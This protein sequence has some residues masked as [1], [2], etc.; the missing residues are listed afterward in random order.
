MIQEMLGSYIR[1]AEGLG[2]Y[3]SMTKTELANGYCDADDAHDE[4]KKNQ[5]FSALMVRYWFKVYD[6][7]RNS[8][9]T[10][11]ELEDY[12]SWVSEAL[13]IGLKYRRWR[14]PSHPL[15]KDPDAPD[16]VFNRALFSTRKRWFMYLN[17]NKRKINFV[18]DSIERQI[19]IFEDAADVLTEHVTDIGVKSASYSIVQTYINNDKLLEALIIDAIAHQ[20][21]FNQK[22]N[23]IKKVQDGE[24]T[25]EV[26]Q[27]SHELNGR[28]IIKLLNEMDR[29]YIEYLESTYRINKDKL[30]NLIVE[31]SKIPNFKLYKYIESTISSMRNNKALIEL[32]Q[33]EL[34]K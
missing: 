24:G 2:D 4:V 9:F 11:L 1:S 19:E 5:Y 14:D 3:K 6:F 28:K 17:K 22:L 13:A 15:S 29:G 23:G 10:R 20:D 31:I 12:A 27:Y 30:T 16:K 26:R 18:A 7:S 33:T 25:H 34:E 32:L 21:T 8:E